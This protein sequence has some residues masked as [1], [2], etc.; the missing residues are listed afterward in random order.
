MAE[1]AYATD[2]KSVTFGLVGSS[3]TNLIKSLYLLFNNFYL[4]E[5]PFCGTLQGMAYGIITDTD[6]FV[7]DNMLDSS[8]EP[9]KGVLV[10]KKKTDALA[11]CMC[12]NK[13]RQGMKLKQC[14]SVSKVKDEDIPAYGVIFDGI[15]KSKL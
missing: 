11:E 8:N 2:L 4:T 10:Y 14:Y 9:R 15:W 12:L 6:I 3:P 7:I 13:L 5:A 1:L